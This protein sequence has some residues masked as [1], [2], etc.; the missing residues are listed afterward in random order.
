MAVRVGHH[1]PA[2]AAHDVVGPEQRR[3]LL[4]VDGRQRHVAGVERRVVVRLHGGEEVGHG[5]GAVV[6]GHGD[7]ARRLRRQGEPIG[8]VGAVLVRRVGRVVAAAGDVVGEL[9]RADRADVGVDRVDT[10]PGVAE[11]Q[12]ATDEIAP[13]TR[14]GQG[15]E[16]RRPDLAHRPPVHGRVLDGRQPVRLD[17]DGGAACRADRHRRRSR[18]RAPAPARAPASASGSAGPWRP[19]RGTSAAGA[20]RA[21]CRVG[22]R[23]GRA[24]GSARARGT[25]VRSRRDA[26][27]A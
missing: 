3:R 18:L 24:R 16:R 13:R 7:P 1:V 11:A 12:L 5:D 2:V 25:G 26:R 9:H 22:R 27:P 4:T 20:A 15:A 19:A 14:L 21:R 10:E 23:G 6:A 8:R 17:L